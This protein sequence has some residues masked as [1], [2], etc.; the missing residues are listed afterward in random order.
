MNTTTDSSIHQALDN[1]AM[2]TA[3]NL[4]KQNKAALAET[5]NRGRTAFSRIVKKGNVQ[6]V[7]DLFRMAGVTC[8]KCLQIQDRNTLRTP[9]HVAAKREDAKMTEFLLSQGAEIDAEM[10]D[11]QRPLHI[12]ARSGSLTVVK[13]LVERGAQVERGKKTEGKKGPKSPKRLALLRNHVEMAIYLDEHNEKRKGKALVSADHPEMQALTNANILFRTNKLQKARKSYETILNRA[14][15]PGSISIATQVYCL[16]KLGILY[17]QEPEKTIENYVTAVKLLNSAMALYD[18]QYPSIQKKAA[19]ISN[20]EEHLKKTQTYYC[21]HILKRENSQISASLSANAKMKELKTIRKEAIK[22]LNKRQPP[23]SIAKTIT[24][25]LKELTKKVIQECLSV[26]GTPPCKEDSYAIMGLGSMSR[27]EMNLYSDVEFGVLLETA[28]DVEKCRTYFNHLTGLLQIKIINFGETKHP[29]LQKAQSPTFTGYSLDGGGNPISRPELLIAPQNMFFSM[30]KKSGDIILANLVKTVCLLHGNEALVHQYQKQ[31][32]EHFHSSSHKALKLL[33][34]DWK[35]YKPSLLNTASTCVNIK[36]DLYRPLVELIH[37]LC[38]CYGI[39]GNTTWKRLKELRKREI[40]GGT[41]FENLQHAFN[42][43]FRLRVATQAHY[44]TEKEEAFCLPHPLKLKESESIIDTLPFT[45]QGEEMKALFNSYHTLVAFHRSL[46]RIVEQETVPESSPLKHLTFAGEKQPLDE[47]IAASAKQFYD[48]V[49]SQY[50]ENAKALCVFGSI[51]QK[52]GQVSEALMCYNQALRVNTTD[53]TL[54]DLSN[55][56]NILE[57]AFCALANIEDS[58]SRISTVINASIQTTTSDEQKFKLLKKVIQ[59]ASHTIEQN[60]FRANLLAAIATVCKK[61]PTTVRPKE[62]LQAAFKAIQTTPPAV[63]TK[64]G[65]ALESNKNNPEPAYFSDI[66]VLKD[67][68]CLFRAIALALQLD[69]NVELAQ[70]DLQNIIF[71]HIEH[72]LESHAA[73]I[74]AQITN[75]FTQSHEDENTL[76]R[77]IPEFF[78]TKLK[79]APFLDIDVSG[80]GACL[81]HAIALGLQLNENAKLSSR[82]LRNVAA[83]HL[84]HNRELHTE[85]IKAQLTNL[86]YQNREIPHDDPRK[87]QFPGIPHAFKTKLI[88]TAET[89]LEAEQNYANSEEGVNDYINHMFDPTAWGGDIELGVLAD[90]LN[91][92]FLIYDRKEAIEPRHPFIGPSEAPKV[93]LLFDGDH[94]GLRIPKASSDFEEVPKKANSEVDPSKESCHEFSR[95]DY[96]SN[97]GVKDYLHAMLDPTTWDGTIKLEALAEL[98]QLELLIYDDPSATDPCQKIGE[99]THPKMH[100]LLTGNHYKVRIPQVSSYIPE[101]LSHTGIETD[102]NSIEHNAHRLFAFEKLTDACINMQLFSVADKVTILQVALKVASTIK[103]A[104]FCNHAITIVEN[105]YKKL[106]KIKENEDLLQLLAAA[107]AKAKAEAPEGIAIR[108]NAHYYCPMMESI[109]SNPVSD[110]HKH[111]FDQK[112]IDI[113]KKAGHKKWPIGKTALEEATPNEELKTNIE[114]WKK[115]TIEPVFPAFL[116]KEFNADL[117]EAHEHIEDAAAHMWLARTNLTAKNEEYLQGIAACENALAYTDDVNV[118]E[119]YAQWL[120]QGNLAHKASRAYAY[121]VKWYG[122]NQ[123]EQKAQEAYQKVK[124]L[125]PADQQLHQTLSRYLHTGKTAAIQKII[126][127]IP[128]ENVRSLLDETLKKFVN[129]PQEIRLILHG[130]SQPLEETGMQVLRK[131]VE[132]HPSIKEIN[133]TNTPIRN[134]A[135]TKLADATKL[136]AILKDLPKLTTLLLSNTQMRDHEVIVIAEGLKATHSLHLLDLSNNQLQDPGA[137]AVTNIAIHNPNLQELD[138]SNNQI[139]SIGALVITKI[140]AKNQHLVKMS[141][142]HNAIDDDGAQKLATA[143]QN[144]HTLQELHLAN[145]QIG[146]SGATAIARALKTNTN[147][148]TL[149]LSGNSMKNEE[150]NTL[151]LV[152]MQKQNFALNL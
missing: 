24:Q 6:I 32:R 129:N 51:L 19:H 117:R 37:K 30:K 102:D 114:K 9:L 16:K 20:L 109:M 152:C 72:N 136:A 124:Q 48:E 98:L 81:F 45:V 71:A 40:I 80:D 46:E 7:K 88:N 128:N 10:K 142:N 68:S 59:I 93:H 27:G 105:A 79:E 60:G 110:G 140:L 122:K 95:T 3:Y 69:S 28:K 76:F 13:A 57:Q 4:L 144:N 61:Q 89:G 54:S 118:Y 127:S 132:L 34:T 130:K 15:I 131:I 50:Q 63:R 96:T 121:L 5:D 12:A 23:E 58:A 137:T 1:N 103:R 49:R 65:A 62:L 35:D 99:A 107:I 151:Q 55:K 82:D 2:Q 42:C 112:A 135:G 97:E 133:I 143:L 150:R 119:Q 139:Q 31:I 84:E 100:L 14:E 11:G 36:N 147:L 108:E 29:V 101:E 86:F 26:L 78:K 149:S 77:G 113:W 73:S 106:E 125:S 67:R 83:S 87:N 47:W 138:L 115:E 74:Q 90:L 104:F 70:Q 66:D 33:Q 120:A 123:E 92:Q 148:N 18:K 111:T 126:R 94:Y 17:L 141:L 56:A 43:I 85:S 134:Q 39:Q 64:T 22:A 25:R 53:E 75:L 116:Q 8:T 21:K 91:L 41:G 44:G 52:T 38:L 146:R 145:N